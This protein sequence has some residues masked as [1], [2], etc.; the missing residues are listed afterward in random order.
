MQALAQMEGIPLVPVSI[1]G[2][3]LIRNPFESFQVDKGQAGF[4]D[5]QQ[6]PALFLATPKGE[7]MPLGQG[8]YSLSELRQ[9]IITQAHAT[10]LI[11]PEQFNSTRPI[12]TSNNLADVIDQAGTAP[13]TD[14]LQKVGG[15]TSENESQVDPQMMLQM[16]KTYIEGGAK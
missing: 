13:W 2:K 8:M 5:V 1:D 16:I 4:L 14:F 12:M 15:D 7:F 11:T 3:N 6:L 10:N 9:R